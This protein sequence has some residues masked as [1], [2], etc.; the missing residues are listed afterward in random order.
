MPN[1]GAVTTSV[2]RALQLQ[3]TLI[4][5]CANLSARAVWTSDGIL[6]DC[7]LRMTNAGHCANYYPSACSIT[8]PP[9]D[10][11][12]IITIPPPPTTPPLAPPVAPPVFGCTASTQPSTD[13]KCIGSTWTFVGTV[14]VPT[15]TVPAG[16]VQ[17]VIQ[18][19]LSSSAIVIVGFGSTLVISDGC[20][21]NLTS[22]TVELTKNDLDK[23]GSKKLQT[24]ISLNSTSNN[25][26]CSNLTEV[27]LVVR[28]THGSCKTASVSK[29]AGQNQLSALFT[30][31]SSGCRTWWII[32]ISVLGGI[33]VLSLIITVLLVLFVRPVREFVRPHSKRNR[34]L[35]MPQ[36]PTV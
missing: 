30:I 5:F 6:T 35:K 31:D 17:T 32:L 29:V 15:L 33:I 10:I 13:W 28:V 11:I 16:A 14:V 1:M 21:T 26:Q 4:D 36:E 18:G 19:N 8:L 2:L 22:V 7:D 3:D 34:R 12:P 23:I 9:L 20:A 27:Q 24:L 25:P